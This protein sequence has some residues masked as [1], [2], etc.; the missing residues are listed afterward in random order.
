LAAAIAEQWHST[1]LLATIAER[2]A[3]LQEVT[4]RR[5]PAASGLSRAGV[6]EATFYKWKAKYGGLE[7]VRA[8]AEAVGR[9]ERQAEADRR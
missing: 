9:R 3:A 4:N 2:A 6:S 7:L 1:F 8:A 5:Y